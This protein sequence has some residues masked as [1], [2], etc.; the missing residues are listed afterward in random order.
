METALAATIP[1]MTNRMLD[2][3]RTAAAA[4]AAVAAFAGP[5]LA[6]D[7]VAEVNAYYRDI[8]RGPGAEAGQRTDLVLFP[9]FIEMT[10]PPQGVDSVR[11]AM[12]LPAQSALW[13]DV[14]AWAAAPEQQAVIA[15]LDRVTKDADY[16]KAM[17]MGQPYGVDA[18]AA[19]SDLEL[20]FI[21]HGLYTELDAGGTPL[22]IA[23]DFKYMPFVRDW[24]GA[25]VNVEATRRAKAGD[26]AGALDVLADWCYFG[27]QLAD[28][29]FAAEKIAGFE[30]MN[31]AL[32]RLRDVVYQ[33]YRGGQKLKSNPDALHDIILRLDEVHADGSLGYIGTR[34]LRF[35]R[36]DLL[37]ARQ[38]AEVLLTGSG[39]DVNQF[40]PAMSRI[41]S[42][43]NALRL[44]SEYAR[45]ESLASE[46]AGRRET[47]TNVERVYGDLSERWKL[48][49]PFDPMMRQQFDL[50]RVDLRRN[51]VVALTLGRLALLLDYRTV[52]RV[53]I[54]GTRHA[55]GIMGVYYHTGDFPND[56]AAVRP[57][58][59][60][61]LEPDPFSSNR[62]APLHYFVPGR[63]TGDDAHQ[64]NVIVAG[65]N[66][67]RKALR[68]DDFIM[69]S[70]GSDNDRDFARNVQNTHERTYDTDYLIWPP[71][72]TL[73][74]EEL[75]RTRQLR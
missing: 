61:E 71:L 62:A 73:V 4:L 43:G 12:L 60:P 56:I 67:F 26:V 52:L 3:V 5:A 49:N 36:A 38:A 39:A 75:L 46:Q 16:R 54:A 25:L 30:I 40:V 35:P 42:S 63:R 13:P 74:R 18:V 1:T 7:Y 50:A 32:E 70:T 6:Q 48:D 24:L 14:E 72:V 9:L 8:R 33:D 21:E 68:S 66:N 28:R 44:F 27:R 58:W 64:M 34:R 23:A 11:K 37:A 51:L 20:S 19:G 69:V 45:W 2:R 22:L 29:E 41:T 65:L 55:L 53:E 10:P 47:L 31:M 57:T 59:V 17:G 15:A